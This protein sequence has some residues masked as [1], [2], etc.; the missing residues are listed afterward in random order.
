M[1]TSEKRETTTMISRFDSILESVLQDSA[2]RKM[3]DMYRDENYF[4]GDLSWECV[5]ERVRM[6]KNR[7]L[8]EK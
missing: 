2:M 8:E 7:M 1:A 6:I 5:N 4:V 3:W